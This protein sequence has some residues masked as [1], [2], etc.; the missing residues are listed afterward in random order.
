MIALLLCI[1]GLFASCELD[2]ARDLCC[3]DKAAMRYTYLPF[4]YELFPT[5]IFN[6]S[7][8]LYDNGGNYLG[9]VPPG[10]DPQYQILTLE[11]GEYT[12][13]TVG[14]PSLGVTDLRHQERDHI[15]AFTLTSIARLED[16]M[17]EFFSNTDELFWGISSFAISEDGTAKMLRRLTRQSWLDDPLYE[18]AMITEMYNIHCHFR[19]RVEWAN[20]PP[21]IGEYQMELDGVST[22]YSLHPE[23]AADGGGFMVPEGMGR[24]KHRIRVPLK[25]QELNGAFVTLR[26]KNGSLPT[27]RIFF[28]ENQVSPDINL[29]KAFR[30]WGWNPDITH[31]QKYSILLRL[32]SDGSADLYPSIDGII[33]DWTDGGSFG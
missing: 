18:T 15:S 25:S 10:S 20:M 23:R 26:L 6:L 1:P 14:N 16:P 22:S 8:Y 24:G 9:M 4:G 7:H 27:L 30:S 17:Q 19:I 28:G 31:V 3:P 32:N 12:M 13:V 11:P 33:E 2:D 29:A 5:Y 21:A